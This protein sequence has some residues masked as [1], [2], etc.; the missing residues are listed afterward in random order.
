MASQSALLLEEYATYH[1]DRRNLICHAI[2][3][4]LIVLAIIALLRL[5]ASR[6]S[7]HHG[8]A[9]L[10]VIAVMIYYVTAFRSLGAPRRPYWPAYVACAGLVVLY[11]IAGSVTLPWAVGLFVL[12]WA[13]QFVGHAFEGKSPAFQTNLLHLLVGPLWVASHLVPRSVSSSSAR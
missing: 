9:E 12:G 1:R 2:G 8:L 5:M 11:V 13:F 6:T 7:Y 4:P 3:I 10:L